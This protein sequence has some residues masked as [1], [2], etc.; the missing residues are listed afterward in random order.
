MSTTM[1]KG[2]IIVFSFLAVITLGLIYGLF[3]SHEI[4]IPK[5]VIQKEVEKRIPYSHTKDLKLAKLNI[6]INNAAFDFGKE[7][8]DVSLKGYASLLPISKNETSFDLSV[9]T[10]LKFVKKDDKLQFYLE[11]KKV[12]VKQLD[13]KE[14]G[15]IA[16][17]LKMYSTDVVST[18]LSNVPVYTYHAK[19]IMSI[20]SI[21]IEPN[22]IIVVVSS[23][24]IIIYF[25]SFIFA[26][27]AFIAILANPEL[28]I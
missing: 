27:L 9:S 7:T 21:K 20:K 23:A 2:K 12:D 26:G 28:F 18:V 24:N 10:G 17:A 16:E 6:N 5:E 13:I 14:S 11:P 25:F 15:K 19:D 4:K 1:T 22:E 8:I 3:S